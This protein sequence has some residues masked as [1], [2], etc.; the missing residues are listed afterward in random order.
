MRV[1]NATQDL[2]KKN[3]VWKQIGDIV[4]SFVKAAPASFKYATV[5]TF[6]SGLGSLL[7]C[8]E[9]V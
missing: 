6:G 2:K 4:G 5:S 7:M 1:D 9:C 8:C 3:N